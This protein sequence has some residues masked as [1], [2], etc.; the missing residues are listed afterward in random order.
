MKYLVAKWKHFGWTDKPD[1]KPALTALIKI[2]DYPVSSRPLLAE[3]DTTLFVQSDGVW[4]EKEIP[5]AGAASCGNNGE[6]DE[7]GAEAAAEERAGAQRA[8]STP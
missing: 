6:D 4:I 3:D 7:G 2:T 5:L 8:A 1:S